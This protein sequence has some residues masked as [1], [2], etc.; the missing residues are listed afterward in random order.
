VIIVNE[1]VWNLW[2]YASRHIYNRFQIDVVLQPEAIQ[3]INDDEADRF[4]GHFDTKTAALCF[5]ETTRNGKIPWQGIVYRESLFHSLPPNLCKEARNDIA[6]EFARQILGKSE[7]KAWEM[8]WKKQESRRINVN[9][10]YNSFMEMN[11]VIS[12]GGEREL[13]SLLHEFQSMARYGRNLDFRDYMEYMNKRTQ[14][15]EVGLNS[16]EIKIIDALLKDKA[17]TFSKLA[18]DLELSNS[19]VSTIVNR[20]KHRFILITG[21]STPFSKIGIRTIHVMLGSDPDDDP[22][23]YI[24]DCPFVFNIQHVLNGPWQVLARLAVPDNRESMQSIYAMEDL[25]QQNG[26]A[27]D[28]TETTSAA[29]LNSFYHYN[30][31][32]RRWEIPWVAMRGWGQ[33]ITDESLDELIE[34]VDTPAKPT[35]AHINELDIA[36]LDLIN[37]KVSSSRILRQRLKV[38]QSRLSK[39][40]NKL[41][42]EGLIRKDWTVYNIGLV[43]RV[44]LR[45][46]DRKTSQMLDLW[47]RELPQIFLRY[48]DPRNLLAITELPA[49]GSIEMMKIIR[50][51]GWSANISLLGGRVWG[52]WTFPAHLWNVE[53]QRWDAPI[54]E[55]A[56]WQSQLLQEIET[57]VKRPSLARILSR[58]K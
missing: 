51:L 14:S 21:T 31:A 24:E 18:R 26:V 55:I 13:D 27:V 49:G 19:W 38:G 2:T 48:E 8:I 39:H 22:S 7:Q 11:W 3:I 42:S 5:S 10:L 47:S 56:S 44:A 1:E 36:I 58:Q 53:N 25:L 40:L 32:N 12:L 45:V 17:T 33:R 15:I 16:T 6:C 35:D 20:L 34:R 46:H 54:E 29:K 57:E 28:I 50:E 52:Q 4:G 23:R 41:Y 37:K 30:V 43:E 9:L